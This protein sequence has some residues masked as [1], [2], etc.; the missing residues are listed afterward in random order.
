MP[1]N[2]ASRRLKK[3]NHEFAVQ[4]KVVVRSYLKNK[5]KTNRKGWGA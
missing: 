2:L 3:E 5:T 4:A 1:V